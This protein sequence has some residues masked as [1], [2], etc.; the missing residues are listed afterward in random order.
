MRVLTNKNHSITGIKWVWHSGKQ[1]GNIS[2]S[3]VSPGSRSE[4]GFWLDY[5]KRILY[6]FGGRTYDSTN[7]NY[8]LSNDVWMLNMKTIDQWKLLPPKSKHGQMP[9]PRYSSSVCGISDTMV[10]VYGGIDKDGKRLGDTWIFELLSNTWEKL[11][12]SNDTKFN[13]PLERGDQSSWCLYHKL[14][15]YGGR[16]SEFKLYHDMWSFSFISLKWTEMES[17]KNYPTS[18]IGQNL[19]SYPKSRSGAT[20][21]STPQENDLYLFGGNT[22]D[23]EGLDQAQIN[24]KYTTD[25]WKYDLAEDSWTKLGGHDDI[26]HCGTYGHLESSS[27]ENWPGC[28]IKASG[29][30][31]TSKNLWMFG[32]NGAD[33]M[34]NSEPNKLLN[35]LWQYDF[36]FKMWTWMGG[37]KYGN[38]GGNYDNSKSENR[39]GSR[40]G[41][42]WWNE[43][44]NYQYIY[45]GIGQDTNGKN[46]LLADLWTID[47]HT[48]VVYGEYPSIGS[49]FMIVFGLCALILVIAVLSLYNRNFFKSPENNER[50]WLDT[51]YSRLH[52]VDDHN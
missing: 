27:K 14:I 31:D 1:T 16:N 11:G 43:L 12:T 48:K 19:V 15:L 51:E 25:L 22:G 49:I 50:K 42:V 8:V 28:R 40:S 32:G 17:S 30:I 5:K 21:F 39:P 26:C 20:T 44:G 6:L 9:S 2:T 38:T 18:Q 10:L 47:I 24:E 4:S 45:G 37:N 7:K 36:T 52:N 33:S 46:G 29:W 41:F 35:D 23:Y 3:L 34:T 13:A